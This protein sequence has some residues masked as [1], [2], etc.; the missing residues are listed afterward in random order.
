MKRIFLLTFS[1]ILILSGCSFSDSVFSG[2]LLNEQVKPFPPES[3]FPKDLSIVA[4]GDSLTKGVGDTTNQGGY[5]SYLKT[6]L[7]SQEEIRTAEFQNFG[8][9]GNTTKDLLNRLN[10]EELQSAIQSSDAVIITVG[11]NDVMEVFKS[12]ILNLK[13]SMFVSA[14]E[15]YS[16]R[17]REIIEKIRSYN[18]NTQILLVGIYNPFLGWFSD[19][20]EM[21]EIVTRWNK[22]SLDIIS[23][24][25]HASLVPIEDIFLNQEESLFHTDYFHPNNLGYEL[26]A[27]RIISHLTENEILDEIIE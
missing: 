27:E 11:G 5:I 12:N 10:N 21:Q 2:K 3:F 16:Q 26:I 17:L 9:S 13:L 20:H 19:I 18:Q 23:T 22:T 8:V 24:F 6:L 14:Q 4:F 1:L 15:G 25:D 7:E